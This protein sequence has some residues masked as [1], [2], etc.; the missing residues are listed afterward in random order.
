MTDDDMVGAICG[1]EPASS[2]LLEVLSSCLAHTY[3]GAGVI[4]KRREKKS[5]RERCF[6][7]PIDLMCGC[8]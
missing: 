7:Y 6:F 8:V 4:I 5:E 3:R 1:F 2:G